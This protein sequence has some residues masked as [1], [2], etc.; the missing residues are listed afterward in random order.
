MIN[1]VQPMQPDLGQARWAEIQNDSSETLPAYGIARVTGASSP[2]PG[3]LVYTV[4][5]PSTGSDEIYVVNGS[6]PIATTKKGRG[7]FDA[8]FVV[9]YDT[10][11]PVVGE[12][13]GPESV[14]WTLVTD[15]GGFVV[16]GLIDTTAKTMLVRGSNAGPT[17]DRVKGLLFGAMA[18]SATTHTIDNV[19]TT[20]GRSPL[21]DAS[22]TTET[23]TVQNDD[24]SWAGDDNAVAFAEYHEVDGLWHLYQLVC[25]V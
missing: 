24:F 16:L 12:E 19:I 18:T 9:S 25:K 17:F 23:L 14:A 5:K 15:S 4:N 10:G 13:W 2:E 1:P 8:P 22:S 7:T 21:A 20:K 6:T 11:T 3:R